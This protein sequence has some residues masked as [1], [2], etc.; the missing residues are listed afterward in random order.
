MF[1][2]PYFPWNPPAWTRSWKH[3]LASSRTFLMPGSPAWSPCAMLKVKPGMNQPYLV[4]GFIPFQKY[5]SIGMI[6]PNIWEKKK[7][8][9]SH[10]QPDMVDFRGVLLHHCHRE[11]KPWLEKKI[12]RVDI[13]HHMSLIEMVPSQFNSRL[14]LTGLTL[15]WGPTWWIIPLS[16]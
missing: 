5:L 2:S 16:K 12:S 10:H 7:S 13:V 15:R 14:G 3:P 11:S 1:G 9:S 8:C 6:I 4:G